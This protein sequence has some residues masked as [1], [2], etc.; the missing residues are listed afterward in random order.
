MRQNVGTYLSLDPLNGKKRGFVLQV[1]RRDRNGFDDLKMESVRW[2]QHLEAD[3]SGTATVKPPLRS[4]LPGYSASQ[5]GPS[6]LSGSQKSIF[7]RDERVSERFRESKI[8]AGNGWVI[9]SQ[10]LA[11][12]SES[13]RFESFFLGLESSPQPILYWQM[14]RCWLTV[15]GRS[16]NFVDSLLIR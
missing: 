6:R 1:P 5:G 4:R 10:N 9:W 11:Q 14:N 16:D 3:G 2:S 15:I 8:S 7:S 12:R 13:C